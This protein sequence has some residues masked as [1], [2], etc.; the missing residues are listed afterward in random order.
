[1]YKEIRSRNECMSFE[2]YWQSPPPIKVIVY[3]RS[4]HTLT[5]LPL[6]D[7]SSPLLDEYEDARLLKGISMSE[8]SLSYA[9]ILFY[10]CIMN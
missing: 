1:M 2:I 7:L 3:V 5:I 9:F 8:F 4:P 6:V 10:F